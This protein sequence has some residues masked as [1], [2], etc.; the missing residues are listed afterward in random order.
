MNNKYLNNFTL[1]SIL[2]IVYVFLRFWGLGNDLWL[3]EIFSV[4]TIRMTW[5]DMFFRIIGDGVHPPL[6]YVL[7]KF[8]SVI[9]Q[10][11]WWLQLFPVAI[12]IL[13]LIPFYLLCREL[14]L[15][16]LEMSVALF[17]LSFN[18]Y[19]IEYSLD[20]RMYGLFQF[21]TLFSLWLFIKLIK[22]EKAEQKLFWQITLINLLIVF[23]HYFGWLFVGLEG[24][25]LLIFHR[26]IFYKFAIYSFGIFI[27]FSFW[28][29]F[30]LQ[31]VANNES[32]G[33]LN[34]LVCPTVSDLTWFY[35]TLNG[36]FNISHTTLLNLLIF[37]FPILIL[38]Y[39]SFRQKTNDKNWLMLA[40]FA[41]AP[42]ILVF[43]L[44]NVLP[45][46]IWQERYLIMSAIPY[47]LLLTK[48][49]FNLPKGLT[50]SG[51]IIFILAWT[52]TAGIFNFWQTPKKIEWSKVV[53]QFDKSADFQSLGRKIYVFEDW[54]E[55]PL[56]FYIKESK[57]SLEV[58]K[59]NGL[60]EIRNQDFEVIYRLSVQ[61]NLLTSESELNKRKCHIEHEN[62]FFDTSQK[63]VIFQLKNCNTN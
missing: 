16:F 57:S 1:F 32:S 20:L 5:Q 61:E 55:D 12:S 10:E 9:S 34:W 18:S 37:G 17:I 19:L 30:V 42:V 48:S 49:L 4:E 47:Q 41:F 54:V 39:R 29:W 60:N 53:K 13:T 7:L 40:F 14:N 52:T 22:S 26:R 23:T 45:K 35:A 3:D 2:I 36:T 11:V 56:K 44:S 28:I 51:F 33:N 38:I 46:S 24:L 27:S 59:R 62:T 6:F 8:W 58:E 21:F 43:I 63:I 25:Y 31:R 15:T 50:K